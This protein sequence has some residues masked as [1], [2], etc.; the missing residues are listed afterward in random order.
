M[1]A[2]GFQWLGLDVRSSESLTSARKRVGSSYLLFSCYIGMAAQ[3]YL[4]HGYAEF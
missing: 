1:N 2:D 4:R 3:G